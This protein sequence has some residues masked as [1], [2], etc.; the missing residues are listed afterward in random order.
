MLLNAFSLLPTPSAAARPHGAD[1][2][3]ATYNI[4][5][6]AGADGVFD[7]PRLTASLRKLDADIIGL[8][9]VD[10]H[11]GDR[12]GWLDL[13]GTLGAALGMRSYAGPIYSFDP[14]AEGAPRREYGNAIL[15]RYPIVS[16]VNHTMTRLSTQTAAP[17]AAPGP[18]LPEVVVRVHGIPVHVYSTHLDFRPDPAVR[19][20]QVAEMLEVLAGDRGLRAVRILMGDFNAAPD[21]PEL[22]PLWPVLTDAWAAAGSGPG[23]TYP[24]GSPDQRI[25]YITVSGRVRV[26]S[27]EVMADADAS[28]HL[29]VVADL[30]LPRG[31]SHHRG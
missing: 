9:E 1:L 15:S 12:S 5:A 3:V 7:L 2:R 24:A 31:G 6:G 16:G 13:A 10:V 8:Q 22:A 30:T 11:W 18:G 4:H 29:P 26:D 20:I 27:V 25:D 17:V 19:R 23:L 28:D 21:A 14:P